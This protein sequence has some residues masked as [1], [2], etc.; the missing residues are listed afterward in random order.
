MKYLDCNVGFFAILS[1]VLFVSPV[2]ASG[3]L[4]VTGYDIA[5]SYV[6]TNRTYAMLNLSLN[7][8]IADI[9]VTSIT[10]GFNGTASSANISAVEIYNNTHVPSNLLATSTTINTKGDAP[11]HFTLAPRLSMR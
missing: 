6:D 11:K 5:P 1:L 10:I 3:N 8:S 2:F 9:N 4:T 7:A